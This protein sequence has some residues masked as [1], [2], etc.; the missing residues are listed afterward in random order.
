ME[1]L[2]DPSQSHHNSA[3]DNIICTH[4]TTNGRQLSSQLCTVNQNISANNTAISNLIATTVA[5]ATMPTTFFDLPGELRNRIYGYVDTAT[6]TST[7]NGITYSA[8]GFID[9]TFDLDTSHKGLKLPGIVYSN[10]QLRREFLPIFAG[11]R[12]INIALHRDRVRVNTAAWVKALGSV[13]I[14]DARQITIEQFSLPKLVTSYLY[15]ALGRRN[16]ICPA[17]CTD[18]VSIRVGNVHVVF[19]SPYDSTQRQ[20][21]VASQ[22]ATATNDRLTSHGADS[23]VRISVEELKQL[24]C[25]LD[26]IYDVRLG[27]MGE[28]WKTDY[29]TNG[30]FAG[31]WAM[32]EQ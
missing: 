2:I 32:V 19:D 10:S 27:G 28:G 30:A 7:H 20:L 11:N 14:H 1:S 23:P 31:F 5:A 21:D 16:V 18:M 4:T 26:T 12:D 25:L 17:E 8:K 24:V 3:A 22:I 15:V 6:G 13:I 9:N 29:V